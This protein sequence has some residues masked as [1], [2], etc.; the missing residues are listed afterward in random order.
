MR[1]HVR[2]TTTTTPNPLN[3]CTTFLFWDDYCRFV[4]RLWGIFIR[5]QAAVF[6][7]SPNQFLVEEVLSSQ[8]EKK[9]R[10]QHL[11]RIYRR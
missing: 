3:S 7:F 10:V 8:I 5:D 9:K 4:P 11:Y 6:F 2:T 1:V